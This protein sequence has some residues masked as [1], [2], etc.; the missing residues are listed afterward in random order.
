M[1]NTQTPRAQAVIPKSQYLQNA[2]EV[3][4]GYDLTGDDDHEG[5]PAVAPDVRP[6]LT[7]ESDELLPQL[8]AAG[9]GIPSGA[10]P[11]AAS[12]PAACRC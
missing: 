1:Q 12:P 3:W 9:A 2:V 11:D 6:R 5:A 8:H 10:A 4:P 7:E